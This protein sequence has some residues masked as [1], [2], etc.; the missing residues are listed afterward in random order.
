MSQRKF[1]TPSS[2]IG[3]QSQI[4]EIQQALENDNTLEG[5]KSKPLVR[6]LFR[7][8]PPAS[9]ESSRRR[10]QYRDLPPTRPRLPPPIKSLLGADLDLAVLKAENQTQTHVTPL[11]A[12][13]AHGLVHEELF[14]VGGRPPPQ[15]KALAEAR[16]KAAH[17]RLR[18]LIKKARV[19]PGKPKIDVRPREDYIKRNSRYLKSVRIN[20]EMYQVHLNFLS[21]VVR[22]EILNEP[23]WRFCRCNYWHY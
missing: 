9:P 22:C 20:G 3:F 2:P 17:A 4:P 12:S 15:N 1:I 16:E 7:R 8:A 14:V 11:I 5:L 23:D 13:L 10:P 18:E 19:L 21:S 6:R